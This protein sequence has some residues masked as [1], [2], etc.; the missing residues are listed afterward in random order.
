MERRV[1]DRERLIVALDVD[2]ARAARALVEGL[3]ESVAFYK[4]GLQLFLGAGGFEITDW[5][6]A[7]GKKVFLDLKFYDVPRTVGAAVRRVRGRGIDLLTVHGDR[8][9]VQAAAAAARE[10]DAAASGAPA[11]LAVTVLTSL[12]PEDLGELGLGGDLDALVLERAR[13]AVRVG[14]A[15]VVASGREAGRLRSALGPAPLVVVPGIRD[16][17]AD[18]DDQ[19]R[20]VTVEDAFGAGASYVVVGRPIRAAPRPRDA[21]E[22]LQGRIAA[23]LGTLEGGEGPAGAVRFT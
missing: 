19:K 3:G 9:I 13:H 21:A 16:P 22:R 6:C 4:V 14:C 15:G 8:A 10:G 5:L 12:A 20:T 17:D 23:V 2:D 18:P 1:P 7:R 11:I